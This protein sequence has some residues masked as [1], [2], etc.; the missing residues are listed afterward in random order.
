MTTTWKLDELL[1]TYRR[2]QTGQSSTFQIQFDPL[3]KWILEPTVSMKLSKDGPVFH[4]GRGRDRAPDLI[5]L[6][7]A[8]E[9]L[10][11]LRS[12]KAKMYSGPMANQGIITL[13]RK[14][15]RL[16]FPCYEI[17]DL[18]SEPRGLTNSPQDPFA[19][20]WAIFFMQ[21]QA[22]I[23]PGAKNLWELT[24]GF[25]LRWKEARRHNPVLE[26]ALWECTHNPTLVLREL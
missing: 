1:E 25:G 3:Q 11:V 8:A 20:T 23:V 21:R 16:S 24:D 4:P 17:W 6:S 9:V 5:E 2:E 14:G 7:S 19:A 26:S 15:E 12:Q 18:S 22:Q 10:T 13:V